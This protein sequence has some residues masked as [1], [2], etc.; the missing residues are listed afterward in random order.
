MVYIHG[1]S[2]MTVKFKELHLHKTVW[3]NP[4]DVTLN[5]KASYGKCLKYDSIHI[6]HKSMYYLQGF[7]FH[8]AILFI[9]HNQKQ[10]IYFAK[11]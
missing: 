9:L 3:M 2:H 6:K 4:N 7:F 10:A 1:I 11:L 5:K 8:L